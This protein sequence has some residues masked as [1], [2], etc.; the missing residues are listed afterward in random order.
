MPGLIRVTPLVLAGLALGA[1]YATPAQA[2]T[3]ESTGEV[4]RVDVAAG[5]VTIQHGAIS[6]LELPAMTLVYRVDPKLLAGIQPGQQVDFTAER[7]DG[8]YVVTAISRK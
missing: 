7:R 2:Q 4:R 1:V 8:K 6:A 5:K 3:A